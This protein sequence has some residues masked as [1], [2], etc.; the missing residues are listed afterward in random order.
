LIYFPTG[1]GTEAY[2]GLVAFTLPLRRLRGKSR[3]DEGRGVAVI[4]RHTLRLLTLD[5]LGR[6]ATLMC[7]LEG[8]RARASTT[9][10]A[11]SSRDDGST[12]TAGAWSSTASAPS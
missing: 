12:C 2:L 3:P 6:A 11:R 1:G 7:A 5:Q 9:T 10:L 4:L 8:P